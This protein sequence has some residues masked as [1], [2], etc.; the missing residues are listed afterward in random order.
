VWVLTAVDPTPTPEPGPAPPSIHIPSAEDIATS[1]L[2]GLLGLLG[3]FVQNGLHAAQGLL[4][5]VADSPANIYTRTP[6]EL[7]YAHPAVVEMFGHMRLI[8]F[9]ALAL[10]FVVAGFVQ[11]AG[12]VMGTDLPLGKLA[13]RAAFAVAAGTTALLWG[14]RLID[15]VNALNASI[16]SVPIGSLLL[17]WPTGFDPIQLAAALLYA[18]VLLWLFFKFAIRV[19]WL[20]ILLAIAPPALFLYTVPQLAFVS[21]AWGRQFFGN[22]FGQPLTLAV[23]RLGSAVLVGHDTSPWD[24]FIGA[25]VALVALQMPTWFVSMALGHRFGGPLAVLSTGRLVLPALGGASVAA[26]VA[27]GSAVRR[28]GVGPAPTRG[29]LPG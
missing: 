27:V 25:A 14:A 1:F 28:V 4:H 18:V 2:N 21:A 3:D 5:A 10:L 15:L 24:Y 29:G 11:M 22:L 6:P 17:P 20:L 8:A 16:L 7:T 19:V 23:L 26:R 12:P 13:V 9:G